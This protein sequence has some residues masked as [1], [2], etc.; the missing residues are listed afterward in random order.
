MANMIDGT[1]GADRAIVRAMAARLRRLADQPENDQRRSRWIAHNALRGDRP[2]VLCFP[3]GAWDEIHPTLPQACVDPF[4]KWVEKVLRER[5]HQAERIADDQIIDPWFDIGW[6]VSVGDYGVQI[7]RHFGDNRGS[8]SWD[9]PLR[10]LERDI[11]KLHYR[12]LSVDRDWTGQAVERV[13]EAFGD[14]LPARIGHFPWWS[15]GLTAEA[16]QMVGMEPLMLAMY[17]Q[18]EQLH[19]LMAFLRDEAMAFIEWHER[20]GLLTPNSLGNSY[21]SSG[22][23]GASAEL[24]DFGPHDGGLKLSQR[25]GFAESQV[26]VGISGSMFEEFILPY[27]LPLLEK[28]GLN[29]YGC[30]EG[31]EHRIDPVLAKIPRLRRLSVAPSANQEVLAERLAGKYIFSRKPQPAHVCVGFNETEI[32]KDIR[33]TLAATGGRNLELIMKDTHTVENQPERLGRWVKIAREELA[34]AGLA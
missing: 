28:F 7:P 19:R 3:E 2:M 10:D 11:D 5:L 8:Y 6:R 34:A 22:G 26:T 31:L 27:Q 9:P 13:N 16:A 33:R 15:L 29:C 20:E 23:V 30:C 32:R 24:G 21:V 25:W 12:S 18:P 1:D 4:W 17:D 14:L